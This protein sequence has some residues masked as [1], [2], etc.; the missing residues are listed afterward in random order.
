[1]KPLRLYRPA[2]HRCDEIL[3]G[4]ITA[5]ILDERDHLRLAG[6]SD[7]VNIH[8]VEHEL[9]ITRTDVE[10]L[11]LRKKPGYFIFRYGGFRQVFPRITLPAFLTVMIAVVRSAGDTFLN[12]YG[13]V[14]VVPTTISGLGMLT[15]LNAIE[16]LMCCRF[17]NYFI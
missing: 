15:S 16:K 14:G 2:L 4:H 10:R 6:A 11:C 7:P 12:E 1:M 13:I 3:Q 8:L 5:F 17:E 9:C